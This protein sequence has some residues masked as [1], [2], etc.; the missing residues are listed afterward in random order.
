[1]FL[2]R[3][4]I[5]L[6]ATFSKMTTS[7]KDVNPSTSSVF[8]FYLIVRLHTK[9]RF[10]AVVLENATLNKY[11]ASDDDS[12]SSDKSNV[13]SLESPWAQS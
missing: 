3:K 13:S 12:A 1:M 4:I 11:Y 8:F 5:T 7:K 2:N 10:D 6:S 9:R